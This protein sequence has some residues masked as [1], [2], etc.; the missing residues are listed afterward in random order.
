M[1]AAVTPIERK[2]LRQTLKNNRDA[3]CVVLVGSV[4]RGTRTSSVGDIDLL[5]INGSARKLLHP[6]VQTTVL[7]M[8]VLRDRVLSGDDFAQWALKFGISLRGRSKW[9]VLQKNLLERA[10]WPDPQIKLEHANRRLARAR[11]LLEMDDCNAAQ[12]EAMYA[13]GHLARA[14]LLDL[15]IFPLSRPELAKQ[16]MSAGEQEV[17]GLVERLHLQ[18]E[19]RSDELHR[20]ITRLGEI[21]G[22]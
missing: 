12:E 15:G 4:A 20:H 21:T 3:D 14:K 11:E 17:A 16:L 10:P 7:T 22:K 19:L 18:N 8:E 5:V 2:L 9:Q 6:G 1:K 13:A